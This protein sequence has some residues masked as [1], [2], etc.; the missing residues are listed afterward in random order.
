MRVLHM[1]HALEC[2]VQRVGTTVRRGNKWADSF[3]QTLAL[4]V[5]AQRQTDTHTCSPE[6]IQG[7][8]EVIEIW[9]GS[10]RDV[11]ARLLE[12]EHEE[13]SRKY[14]GLLESMRFAYG[15]N[16]SEDEN[17]TIVVYFRKD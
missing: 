5:C 3:G 11:P 10:F 12:H 16:F 2:P 4:C 1:L 6:D 14:S 13:R 7:H 8:G 15:K 17:V 9:N